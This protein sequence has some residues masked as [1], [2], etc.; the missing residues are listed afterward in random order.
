[1]MEKEIEETINSYNNNAERYS[2]TYNLSYIEKQLKFYLENFNGNRILDVGCGHGRDASY[3]SEKGFDVVGID[4]SEELLKTARENSP[5]S[6]FYLM[7]MRHLDFYSNL[8]D[9]IWACSSFLHVPYKDAESTL[10]GFNRVLKPEGLMFLCVLE[11]EGEKMEKTMKFQE[12][13]RF[14]AYYSKD[15]IEDLMDKADFNVINCEVEEKPRGSWI[16]L[17]CRKR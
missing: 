14:F 11:G 7:D 2:K 13:E 15:R 10:K 4:L 8:F 1:M 17:F 5:K 9:G 3:F 6:R 16:N 12:Y